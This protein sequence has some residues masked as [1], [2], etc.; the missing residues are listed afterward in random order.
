MKKIFRKSILFLF[1][2]FFCLTLFSGC[3]REGV[4]HQITNYPTKIVYEVGEKPNF[5][6]IR[7]E[8]LNNDG[9]HTLFHVSKEDIGDIDTS[10]PG[11]KVVKV[12]KEN[13][14][15]SFPIYVANVIVNDSDNI[16]AIF[17]NL[18]D[19]DIVY[20]RKG[21]YKPL[22]ATDTR[23]KDIVVDKSVIIVGDG[24][25]NT[26]FY[27]NFIVGAT[28]SNGVFTKIDDFENVKI[29]DIGFKLNYELKDNFVNYTGGYGKTDKNGAIRCFDTKNLLITKCSFENYGYGIVAE[30]VSGLKVSNC[31]FRN[32]LKTAI[33]VENDISNSTIFK[34]VFVDI[35]DNVVAIENNEQSWVA[36]IYLNFAT[37]GEKGVIIAKNNFN[38]IG[39]H[40]S[41][42]IYFDDYSRNFVSNSTN[43]LFKMSY[44]NNSSA[45]VLLSSSTD[46]LLVSG[47]VLSNNNYA[48]AYE[49]LYMGAKSEKTINQ[50]GV[51]I[52]E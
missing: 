47:I 41:S 29:I 11:E 43:S 46:D 42:L 38:R 49:S 52:L 39:V 8:T 44:M 50:N 33:F 34:N 21:E 30:S 45:I 40:N 25:D 20:M 24:A 16:K 36:G 15:V 7:I 3:A 32:I 28:Y 22:T 10:T 37:K 14:S 26:K 23:Y 13:V 51:I 4:S 5:D 31:S 9:T 12:E 17:A 1:A 27:G 48:G 35:A 2:L 19:G 6:G 18:K